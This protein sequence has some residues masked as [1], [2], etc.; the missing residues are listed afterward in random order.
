MFHIAQGWV[1][2]LPYT[3]IQWPRALPEALRR[4]K[5][6]T[7]VRSLPHPFRHYPYELSIPFLHGQVGS[8]GRELKY[9]YIGL[10][11]QI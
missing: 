1:V 2:S 8:G 7:R 3:A 5:I 6:H 10:R 11:I 4:Q 9:E